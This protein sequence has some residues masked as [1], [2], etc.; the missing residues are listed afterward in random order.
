MDINS[1]KYNALQHHMYFLIIGRYA[2]KGNAMYRQKYSS[3]IQQNLTTYQDNHYK[4]IYTDP[5]RYLANNTMKI[6]LE[7][8]WY[9]VV[10]IQLK[11]IGVF[12][13][14]VSA[15]ASTFPE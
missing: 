2:R 11:Q 7:R 12:H 8:F 13:S 14:N 1:L 4:L 15:E 9:N 6:G 10:L 3:K 5:S